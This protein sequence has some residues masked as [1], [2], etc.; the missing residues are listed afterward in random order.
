MKR[1][2]M[3][4]KV[5]Q[6]IVKYA[7]HA[8]AAI[9]SQA[10]SPPPGNAGRHFIS[11]AWRFRALGS[12][13]AAAI[14]LLI[15]QSANAGLFN[16]G[17]DYK[18]PTN[19]TPDKYKAED[20]GSWKEGRPLDRVPKGTWWEVFGDLTLND[21]EKQAAMQNQNL[22]AAVARVGQA[23][24]TARVARGELMPTLSTD[25]SWTRQ[26]YSPNQV[27]SFGN[28][29]ANAFSVPLDFSYEVDLW[30]R[31]RRGFESA[32]AD[33]QAS[34]A[35]YYNVLLTLQSDV[36]QNYFGL[37]SLDAEIAIVA[38]T[39]DLRKEQVRLVRSRFEGGIGN[40]LD[41]ARAETEQATTEADLAS[42]ARR[43]AELENALAILVGSDPSVF[44]LSAN[45]P[46]NW[47]PTPP[48]VPAGLPGELLER[49]P[50]VGEA[51]RSLASAN[52]KIGVAKA[53]FFPVVNLTASGGYLSGEVENLFNWGSRVWSIGPSISLPLFAGGRNRANYHRSQAAFEEA[54]A[55]YR[56]Q[57]LVAFGDVENSLSGIRHLA[58]QYA[59]QQRAVTQA[60]RSAD[61]ATQRYRS[62][63]V[64]YIEV[65]DANR[66]ELQTE[67]G[68]AQLTGQRL[69]T[70]VQLIKAL[71]GGWSDQQLF[72]KAAT[73]L[74]AKNLTKN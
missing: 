50:D 69:I 7:E 26:R 68:N 46:D 34:L 47:N 66:D 8:K 44:R 1:K 14:F 62:G 9:P 38:S 27:P 40:E 28:V 12:S 25:P 48:E 45:T 56:Q 6:L 52:A 60:R 73:R 17:P 20:L 16:V 37:R 18:E 57:V 67:R 70:T 51:E 3:N 11:R 23:R 15:L 33:A 29:T 30:G 59:A 63:I 13:V 55:H 43:R 19:A 42:L 21:L 39:V 41:V 65:I 35:D 58:D 54:V 71:G 31:V 10:S 24:A 36:A 5:G 74:D 53:A 64:A 61:L 49:R 22:K 4:F 72:T 32:R 2:T